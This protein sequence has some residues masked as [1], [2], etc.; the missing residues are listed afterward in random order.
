[1]AWKHSNDEITK[2]CFYGYP[3][4]GFYI[5]PIHSNDAGDSDAYVRVKAP[6][7]KDAD[8]AVEKWCQFG[9]L[10]N[11]KNDGFERN[12]VDRD[13][14]FSAYLDCTDSFEKWR[15]GCKVRC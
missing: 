7:L 1:M 10:R 11:G 14:D 3:L 2:A 5:V 13:C 4:D 15:D 8:D 9:N 12:W 6:S